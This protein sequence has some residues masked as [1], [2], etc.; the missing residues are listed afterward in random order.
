MHNMHTQMPIHHSHPSPVSEWLCTAT[1][2]LRINVYTG[3]NG[4]FAVLTQANSPHPLLL[5][6]P[7]W[8]ACG[9]SLAEMSTL[10]YKESRRRGQRGKRE[11]EFNC[12][13]CPSLPCFA[14][15]KPLKPK[16]VSEVCHRRLVSAADCVGGEGYCFIF[17]FFF[18]VLFFLEVLFLMNGMKTG[19]I[20]KFR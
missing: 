9:F 3:N 2:Q 19:K 4:A 12:L 11:K 15:N 5:Q 17:L 6:L 13:S 14:L 18:F 20:K 10:M 7:P 8:D 16:H 1:V